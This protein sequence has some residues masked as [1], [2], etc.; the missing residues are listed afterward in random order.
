MSRT[1]I[2]PDL[3]KRIA[4]DKARQ[5]G[6]IDDYTFSVSE[7]VWTWKMDYDNVEQYYNDIINALK[8][9]ATETLPTV[10][11]KKTFKALL[12]F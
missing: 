3:T 11:F 12:E 5:N 1:V 6:C 7:S 9:A 4:W 8:K 2:Y 10:S